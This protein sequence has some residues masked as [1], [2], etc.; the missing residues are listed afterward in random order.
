[1]CSNFARWHRGGFLRLRPC[2]PLHTKQRSRALAPERFLTPPPV[3][4][5]PHGPPLRSTYSVQ[6]ETSLSRRL[7]LPTNARYCGHLVRHTVNAYATDDLVPERVGI[8]AQQASRSGSMD[9]S[10]QSE[11]IVVGGIEI[12]DALVLI[13]PENALYDRPGVVVGD[14]D[15]L[16][17]C[18]IAH[19]TVSN[20]KLGQP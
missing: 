7:K 1:M 12:K 13:S 9:G 3:L 2:C 20:P 8:V 19:A 14:A 16:D 11:E 18:E 4:S 5:T 10:K 17:L 6:A 15:P